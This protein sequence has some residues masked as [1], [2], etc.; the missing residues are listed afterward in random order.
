MWCWCWCCCCCCIFCEWRVSRA[1]I[2]QFS[3]F[4]QAGKQA[5][6]Q[7]QHTF[8]V[9]IGFSL[10]LHHGV[11][12]HLHVCMQMHT[13]VQK[14]T[15]TPNASSSL[16]LFGCCYCC[17]APAVSIC[18]CSPLDSIHISCALCNE[19]VCACV[20]VYVFVR[21]RA[22]LCILTDLRVRWDNI[23]MQRY[24]FNAKSIV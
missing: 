12:T 4:S 15:G 1:L 11:A 24:L 20:C 2:L 13:P 18:W 10:P 7:Q 9:C 19:C 6:Q 3:K 23:C 22:R 17:A 5:Q 16:S 14:H 8:C 21:V